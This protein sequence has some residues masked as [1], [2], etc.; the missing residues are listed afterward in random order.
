[1][2]KQD[3]TKPS[4]RAGLSPSAPTGQLIMIYIY[5]NNTINNISVLPSSFNGLG[6]RARACVVVLLLR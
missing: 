6:S 3:E 4:D 5:I 2:K 1:M